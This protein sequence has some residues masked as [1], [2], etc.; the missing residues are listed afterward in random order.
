MISRSQFGNQK[1]LNK[2]K[3]E[4]FQSMVAKNFV[5]SKFKTGIEIVFCKRFIF[6]LSSSGQIS[7]HLLHTTYL[8]WRMRRRSTPY[9]KY[10]KSFVLYNLFET[11]N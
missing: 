10:L 5:K 1:Q 11:S 9:Q 8:F 7:R 3:I 4:D 2:T 6:P